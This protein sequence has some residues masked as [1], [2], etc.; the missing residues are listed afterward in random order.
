MR[1]IGLMSGTSLDGVDAALLETDGVAIG[2]AGP[3]LT[4]AYDATLRGDLRRLLDR[5]PAL[6]PDDPALLDAVAR[7]TRR[8]AEAVAAIG[9]PADLIGFHGQTI[10]HQPQRRRTWQVGDAAL[11]ARLTALPVAHDFRA[12]DVAAG[13]EGAPL[14][15]VYHA[16]LAAGLAGPLAVLNLGGVG[17]VTF[18]GAD[19][20]LLAFDT[21]PGNGP[22][23]DW[24]AAHTNQDCDRD[25]RLSAAGLADPIVLARLLAHP[26]FERP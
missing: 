23:D 2:A 24:A 21:G 15:P 11:L 22:L 20:G 5:A 9:R 7:L 17:N 18:I 1:V 10:L 13:G 6:P 8:H 19:G 12:A 14:V 26:Y 3:A 4:L 16:A 25:G